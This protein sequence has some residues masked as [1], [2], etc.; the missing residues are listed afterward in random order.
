MVL[1]STFEQKRQQVVQ[2]LEAIAN[3]VGAPRNVKKIA[4]SAVKELYNDKLSPSVRAANVI[5][6]IE[7]VISDSNIPSYTRTQLWMVISILETIKSGQY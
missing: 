4:T 2:V 1:S 7:D 5:D 6:M 3:E